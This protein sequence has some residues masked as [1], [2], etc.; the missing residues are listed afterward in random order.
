MLLVSNGIM[1]CASER[2]NLLIFV[3]KSQLTFYLN[4]LMM[5]ICSWMAFLKDSVE[6]KNQNCSLLSLFTSKGYTT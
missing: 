2:M 6:N 4:N 5:K 1:A 3:S